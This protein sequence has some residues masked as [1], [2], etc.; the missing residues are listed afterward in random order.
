MYKIIERC[1]LSKKKTKFNQ[2]FFFVLIEILVYSIK[3]IIHNIFPQI[4]LDMHQF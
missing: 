4:N 3:E 2:L 1:F